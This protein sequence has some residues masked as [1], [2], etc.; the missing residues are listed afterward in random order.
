M[1]SDIIDYNAPSM[2][3]GYPRR[4]EDLPHGLISPPEAVRE[5]LAK[6]KAKHP[7]EVFNAACEE[8][9]LNQ[10]TVGYYFDYLGHE[11]IYR[12]TPAGPDVLAVGYEEGEALRRRVGEEEY[13]KFQTWMS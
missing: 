12:Q 3:G 1:S 8:R 9:I 7:P 2:Q 11:V 6:E 4:P 5:L 10:W 13:R